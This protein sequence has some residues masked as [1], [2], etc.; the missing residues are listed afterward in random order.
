[1]VFML[2]AQYSHCAEAKKPSCQS[3]ATG[4]IKQR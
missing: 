4:N 1:M 3:A 2:S